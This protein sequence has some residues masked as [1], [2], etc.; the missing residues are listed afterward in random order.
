MC[1]PGFKNKQRSYSSQ[2]QEEGDSK[3]AV[4]EMAEKNILD[5][6]AKEEWIFDPVWF[7][8]EHQK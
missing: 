6:R 8:K 7:Q 3:K 5:D 2:Q 4:E 1:W